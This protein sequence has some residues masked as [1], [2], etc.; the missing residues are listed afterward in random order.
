MLKTR[1]STKILALVLVLMFAFSSTVMAANPDKIYATDADKNNLEFQFNELL[2]AYGEETAD[3]IQLWEDSN[4][5]ALVFGDKVLSFADFLNKFADDIVTTPEEYSNL[6][7]AEV[8]AAP[9]N[10]RPVNADG[11]LGEEI[12]DP[13][14]DLVVEAVS[15]IN[16]TK[17]VKVTVDPGADF[18][19]ATVTVFPLDEDGER[20]AALD[21]KDITDEDINE[22]GKIVVEFDFVA[23]TK[24]DYVAV[25]TVDEDEVAEKEFDVD[26]TAEN[27]AVEAVNDAKTNVALWNALQNELF[28]GVAKEANIV[29]YKEELEVPFNTVAEVIEAV[30]EINEEVATE[31]EFE[32]LKEALEAAKDN[33]LAVYNIL[34][35]KFGDIVKADNIEEYIAEIFTLDGDGKPSVV[36]LETIKAIQDAIDDV[37]KDVADEAAADAVVALIDELP[38]EEEITLEDKADVVAARAA[39]EALTEDQQELVPAEKVATL[40]AAE[41]A[42][43][44]AEDAASLQALVKAAE[45][46]I[47]AL[48]EEIT[49]EHKAI[50]ENARALVEA[51]QELD[52][53]VTI[54]NI[55]ILEAAET[56]ITN[57]RIAA[58]LVENAEELALALANEEVETI[59]LANGSYGDI[60]IRRE[61][62]LVAENKHK[63]VLGEVTISSDNVTVDGVTA[64]YIDFHHVE[65]ITITN[66]V[67]T[68]NRFTVAI[69]GAGG[70]DNG[71]ATIVNNVLLNGA[72]GLYTTKTFD[73]YTITGNTIE[74]AS[75]EGIWLAYYG[76]YSD[77]IT[78]GEADSIADQLVAE[79][80][81]GAAFD[82]EDA[83]ISK[84]KVAT[85]LFDR[86][87]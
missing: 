8:V 25:V 6:T 1:R 52:A 56:A 70:D 40:E 32:A 51:A 83:E 10:V 23:V 42:I 17:Q 19:A 67:V 41:D 38:E 43:E 28:E 22:E 29:K 9:E 4:K 73:E 81:F 87:R 47:E 27:E 60:T 34:K 36:K 39:Y 58:G 3:Y 68:G 75:D 62:E 2:D 82:A 74:K 72:I 63:A 77:M 30:K 5:T 71:A 45:E 59:T 76:D 20:E 54:S 69:G 85:N 65:D 66:N 55:A 21:S 16:N 12:V 50:V 57:A 84:V 49:L 37:N 78:L 46:A 15:A 18:E 11:T 80:T 33:D 53:E 14:G 7:D 44:A 24:G 35:D 61:V 13:E 86:I 48:P 31:G 79:N 64:E 26:F